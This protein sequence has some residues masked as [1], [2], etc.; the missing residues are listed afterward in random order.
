MKTQ[1]VWILLTIAALITIYGVIT[2]KYF[3]LFLMLPFGF[4]I[5]KRKDKDEDR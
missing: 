2:G 1:Y 3:F 4:G 5:F